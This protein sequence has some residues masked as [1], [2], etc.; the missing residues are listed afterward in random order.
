MAVG[1]AAGALCGCV[2][3]GWCTGL[4]PERSSEKIEIVGSQ[5]PDV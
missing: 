2:G 5:T 3:C 4:L 1:S